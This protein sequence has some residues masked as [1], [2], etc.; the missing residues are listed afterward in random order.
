MTAIIHK[1]KPAYNPLKTGNSS[2]ISPFPYIGL[3]KRNDD[4][5]T[6]GRLS[7][8]IPEIGGDPND[9]SSWII[10]SYC[11]PFAGSTDITKI[12]NY[13]NDPNVAQQ[14]YG[15]VLIPPDLNNEVMV[16]FVN[17]NISRAYWTGCIFQQ[18]MNHMVPG[19]AIDNTTDPN[20]PIAPVIEYNKG[21][22]TGTV[23][24]PKRPIFKPLAEGLAAEGLTTDQ[25]RGSSS[26]SMRREAPSKVFGLLSPRANTIHIDDNEKNEFIRLR[27]RS[28]AQVLIHETT[29][30]V[31]INSKNGNSWFEISDSGIDAFTQGSISLRA[32]KDLNVRAD[33][34]IIFDAAGSIFMQAGKEINLA[35]T[36]IQ[37][38][39]SND[40]VLS[41]GGNINSVATGTWNRKGS[42]IQDNPA[43][44]DAATAPVPKT[45]L[46][47]TSVHS[48]NNTWVWQSGGGNVKTIVG[49]MPT[50]EPWIGH[51]RSDIPPLP[52]S[53][54]PV[55][56][57]GLHTNAPNQNVENGCSFGTAGT[58]PIST[59]VH[60]SITAAADKTG[61]NQ[62]TLLAFADI[63]SS[64]NPNAASGSSSAKG[65]FQFTDETWTGMVSQ[66][67]NQLNVPNSP[68]SI[69]NPNYNA[70]MG[71]QFIKNNTAILQNNGISDP[72]PGQLYITHFMGS[73]GGPKFIKEAQN[74]PDG[75]AASSNPSAAAKNRN[76]YYNSDGSPKT[77]KQVYDS[78]TSVADSKANAYAEQ[79]GLQPPC[80]RGNGVAGGTGTG[81]ANV[82]GGKIDPNNP[83][84]S[85][86]NYVGKYVSSGPDAGSEQCVALVKSF[87]PELGS[88]SNWGAGQG[89]LVN[90]PPPIGTA[91][92]SGWNSQGQYIGDTSPGSSTHAA[93][94]IG[95]SDD[96]T[97]IKVLE[98]YTGQ[99][100]HVRD[101]P[102]TGSGLN[103]ANNYRVINRVS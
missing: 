98:Q 51:P 45:T 15:L 49:R 13:Q 53:K 64:F 78:L 1:N 71:A 73:S 62:A 86:Q 8:W 2:N 24:S 10:C 82:P 3:V 27:T 50:H 75:L 46:D 12:P 31:Y 9:E 77:N 7:V 37:I 58:K 42:S 48:N 76:I 52:T 92:A 35:S 19:I 5:Q 83:I 93:E 89:D 67:G 43:K 60:N 103:N 28:G 6:M 17:G 84:G 63:E 54:N 41:A 34:N 87:H 30:Y 65:L 90:N 99:P 56:S 20:N 14:S 39:A 68:D 79:N 33:G 72:T 69:N 66:Y 22:I 23:E 80:T 100:A 32:Q 25:E 40:L 59:D 97:G 47:T 102:A 88:T 81:V 4:A 11:S 85:A 57:S 29:G 95:K 44:V 16:Q 96:G 55:N 70:L 61:V 21:K 74:N 101:Y 26:S 91:I 18:N 94:Y 38:G 36:K